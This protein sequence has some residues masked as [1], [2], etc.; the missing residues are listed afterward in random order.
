MVKFDSK[1]HVLSLTKR[2]YLS[3]G[4]T[5]VDLSGELDLS[6]LSEPERQR[7]ISVAKLITN[8]CSGHDIEEHPVQKIDGKTVKLP[9]Q[10][11]KVKSVIGKT[12]TEQPASEGTAAQKVE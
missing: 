3:D 9:S 8:W 12:T 6:G 4:S 11:E 7:I 2:S 5:P 1:T 10:I